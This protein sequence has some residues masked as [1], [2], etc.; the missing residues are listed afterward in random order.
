MKP[1]TGV[2]ICHYNRNKQLEKVL[3]AVKDTVSKRVKVVVC[4]D[5]SDEVPDV[6][7]AI[8]IRGPNLG[9]AANKNRGLFALQDMDFICLLEDDLMPIKENW[10]N[11]YEKAAIHSGIHHFCR[12]VDHRVESVA[13]EFDEYMLKNAMTPIYAQRPRG[14]FTFITRR[15]VKEVGGF[16]KRF[17]GVGYAHTE[18]SMRVNRA[19]LIG[20]PNAWVD[21]Q[22]GRDSLVTIGDT[23]GGRWDNLQKSEKEIVK[24]KQVRRNLNANPYTFDKLELE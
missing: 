11:H 15:V 18:W 14:D 12:V 20:H 5:G 13:P 7:N 23:E 4:D 24:N 6:G 21:I 16:N 22:E 3:A 17:R 10:L 9:V 19:G 8:L 2:A 1:N